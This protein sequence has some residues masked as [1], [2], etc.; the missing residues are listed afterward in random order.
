M[1]AGGA[2]L[3]RLADRLRFRF[4]EY[5]PGIA[6]YE[7]VLDGDQLLGRV[8]IQRGEAGYYWTAAGRPERYASNLEAAKA[9]VGQGR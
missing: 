4:V 1:M 3:M 2:L 7:A 6:V 5:L 9:L 8:Q